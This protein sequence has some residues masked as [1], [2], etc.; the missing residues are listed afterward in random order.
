MLSTKKDCEALLKRKI[1]ELLMQLFFY[2]AKGSIFE[3]LQKSLMNVELITNL[4]VRR[5]KELFNTD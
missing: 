5:F 1:T 3:K 4:N 2:A